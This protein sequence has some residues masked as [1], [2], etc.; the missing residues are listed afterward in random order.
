MKS[1]L[2]SHS[3]EYVNKL[4][5]KNEEYMIISNFI[6]KNIIRSIK[7]ERELLALTMWTSIQHSKSEAPKGMFGFAMII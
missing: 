2:G 7:N 5:T 6:K 4:M 1:S 3:D